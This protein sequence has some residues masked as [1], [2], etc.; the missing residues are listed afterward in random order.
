MGMT[1]LLPPE[2]LGRQ[3]GAL[4][5][6]GFGSLDGDGRGEKSYSPVFAYHKSW[7]VPYSCLAKSMDVR[8]EE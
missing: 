5:E 1:G 2:A 8:S 7:V 6:V 3:W 4:G